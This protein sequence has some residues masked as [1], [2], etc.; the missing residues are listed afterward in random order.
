[1]YGNEV[2]SEPSPERSR[3][4]HTTNSSSLFI[5]RTD[6]L[7]EMKLRYLLPMLLFFPCFFA[8]AVPPYNEG[9]RIEA[10]PL[11]DPLSGLSIYNLSWIAREDALY[12]LEASFDLRP[13]WF[14]IG[15]VPDLGEPSLEE[16]QLV[17]FGTSSTEDRL[18]YRVVEDNGI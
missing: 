13:P 17:G 18:F 2:E 4:E 16:D 3:L 14:A 12:T 6:L 8:I 5:V 7:S 11:P 15:H 9:L 1:M 10:E